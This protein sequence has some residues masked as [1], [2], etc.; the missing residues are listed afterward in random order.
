MRRA[1]AIVCALAV[2]LGAAAAGWAAFSSVTTNPSTFSAAPD[3]S[4]PTVTASVIARPGGANPG[5]IRQGGQYY[6]YANATDAG[7]PA[8]GISSVTAN[9]TSFDT[10]TGSVALTATGGPWTIGA[11]SYTYRSAVLTANTPL[12]TGNSYAYTVTANDN[13]SH[14]SGATSFSVTIETYSEVIQATTGLVSYWRLGEAAGTTAAD[15]KGSNTGTYTN[16]PI[17]GQNGAL[18]GDNNDSVRFTAANSQYVDIPA[19][20]TLDLTTGMTL[21]A[22]IRTSTLGSNATIIA[23]SSAGGGSGYRLQRNGTNNTASFVTAGTTGTT[24]NSATS[25]NDGAWH[26]IVV[27]YNG[28]N[29]K[30]IYIDGQ[31]DASV[32]NLTGTLNTTANALRI[33]AQQAGNYWDGWIDEVAVYNTAL[34]GATV[35]DHYNAG[36]GNG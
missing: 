25:I 1:G 16:T 17:L 20:A 29:T 5:K 21:E 33:A 9:L 19:A 26:Q 36:I 22:W 30:R 28:G 13:A 7:N 11:T 4:N 14:S 34:A 3:L 27:T 23:K 2:A 35:L 18:A 10:G 24:L 32:T 31:L 8:S 15:S 12:T 6:V